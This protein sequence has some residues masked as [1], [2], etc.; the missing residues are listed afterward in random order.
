VA[1]ANLQ[2]PHGVTK[3]NAR[4]VGADLAHSRMVVFPEDVGLYVDEQGDPLQPND[5]PIAD[6]VRISAGYRTSSRRSA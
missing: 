1:A 4:V 2:L 3:G 5:F 6:A